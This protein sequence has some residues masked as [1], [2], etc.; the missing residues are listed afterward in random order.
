MINEYIR[1]RITLERTDAFLKAYE[2]AGALMRA[3]EFCLGYELSRCAEAPDHFI[4]RIHWTSQDEHIKGFRTG[5]QWPAFLEA[6]GPFRGDIE[7]MRHYELTPLR[8][9]RSP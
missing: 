8:W 2:A 5:P 6:V 7:E 9:S 3:S 4:L 1:Y